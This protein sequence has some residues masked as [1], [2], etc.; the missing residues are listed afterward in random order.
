M[1]ADATAREPSATQG[2]PATEGPPV[3]EGPSNRPSGGHEPPLFA[4]IAG[5]GTAGHVL[6]GVAVAQALVRRGHGADTLLFVGSQRGVERSVVP[7]AGFELLVLPGRGIARR[8]TPDNIGAVLGLVRAVWQAVVMLRRRRPAVVL[9]LGGYAS[10]A[11]TVGAVLWRIPLVVTEQNA[12]AGLANKVAGR[13]AQAC[14]VPFEGTDL[15]RSVVTGN[16]VRAELEPLGDPG[17]RVQLRSQSRQRLGIGDQDPMMA[18]FSGS[19]GARRVNL[20]AAGLA[21]RWSNRDVVLYHVTGTRDHDLVIDELNGLTDDPE[22]ALDLRVVPYENNME[23]VLAAADVVLCRSGG[24]T[25]AELAVAGVPAVLVPLPGAPRDHQ[26]AN[27]MP[28]VHAGGAIVLDDADCTA[29]A[30]D[31][32]VSPLLDDSSRRA[33]M[34]TGLASVARP[35]AAD[36]VAA[37]V[38]EHARVR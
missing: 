20:A 10:V 38:E 12:V 6:P 22:C 5:G 7:A 31:A 17:Q 29:D 26:R 18:V 32:L 2:P 11:C 27:A 9:S 21:R 36:R 19:L 24:T 28:L 14:A 35:D 8:F 3:S 33:A 25:V 34:A 1:T 37:L 16:P 23:H 15:P 30:V 4:V 13:F